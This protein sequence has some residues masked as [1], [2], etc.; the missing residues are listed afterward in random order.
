MCSAS[1][2]V[3]RAICALELPTAPRRCGCSVR[4]LLAS[5]RV[6]RMHNGVF[7]REGLEDRRSHRRWNERRMLG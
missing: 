1:F 6:Q 4:A 2:D 7:C 3:A 5:G